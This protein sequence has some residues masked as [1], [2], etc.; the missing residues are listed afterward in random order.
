M[1]RGSGGEDTQGSVCRDPGPGPG[2]PAGDITDRETDKRTGREMLRKVSNTKDRR[3]PQKHL[4]VGS[5]I[6][7]RFITKQGKEHLRIAINLRNKKM[8]AKF[9]VLIND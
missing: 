2:P 5:V 3:K 1:R 9:E 6:I 4:S 8:I 7:P